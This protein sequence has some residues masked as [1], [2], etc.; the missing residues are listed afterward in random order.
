M[1]FSRFAGNL[2]NAGSHMADALAA[3]V[4]SEAPSDENIE[5]TPGEPLF[6][7]IASKTRAAIAVSTASD[8][9]GVRGFE[10]ELSE[11]LAGLRVAALEM[12]GPEPEAAFLSFRVSDEAAKA[13]F[14]KYRRYVKTVTEY[15]CGLLSETSSDELAEEKN[16][17]LQ[18][19]REIEALRAE[20]RKRT[21]IAEAS[22]LRSRNARLSAAGKLTGEIDEE[23][24]VGLLRDVSNLRRIKETLSIIEPYLP[25]AGDEA[26]LVD[27]TLDKIAAEFEKAGLSRKS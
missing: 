22:V 15:A 5:E 26:K 4:A 25:E 7:K 27:E 3:L 11:A 20:A 10:R 2:K 12:D 1:D 18:T 16:S 13:V 23:T 21:D 24:L 19:G 6:S 17:I 14:H 9:E 8:A